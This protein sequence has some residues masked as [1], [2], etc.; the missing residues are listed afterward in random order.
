MPLWPYSIADAESLLHGVGPGSGFR[1]VLVFCVHYTVAH[2]TDRR[3]WPVLWGQKK[4]NRVNDV[5]F[6]HSARSR[7]AV[8][9]WLNQGLDVLCCFCCELRAQYS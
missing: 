5:R 3:G 7:N 1:I 2:G 8:A 9:L 4:A 6:V